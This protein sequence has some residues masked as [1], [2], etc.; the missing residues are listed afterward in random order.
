[1]QMCE[2]IEEKKVIVPITPEKLEYIK[3]VV[4]GCLR[5]DEKSWEEFWTL[6]IPTIKKAIKQTLHRTPHPELAQDI[7]NVENIFKTIVDKFYKNNKLALCK[8]LSGIYSWLW[9]IA[10]N[11]TRDWFARKDKSGEID[12]MGDSDS[13]DDVENQ[14]AHNS[15]DVLQDK[16]EIMQALNETYKEMGQIDNHKYKWALRLSIIAED[17][18]NNEEIS[19][20]SKE[21]GKYTPDEIKDKLKKIRKNL[22]LKLEKKKNAGERADALFLQMKQMEKE[23]KKIFRPD[24]ASIAEKIS[25]LRKKIEEKDRIRIE[26]LAEAKQICRPSNEEIADLIGISEKHAQHISTFLFRV[27]KQLRASLEE[28]GFYV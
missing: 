28:K 14:L 18:L 13:Y 24:D 11:D 10:H 27:R 25:V 6:F 5:N 7:D 12:G 26:H 16:K 23:I 20:L 4:T 9:I 2:K 15:I 17:Y 3:N 21:F 8:D 22:D 19:A 1:M